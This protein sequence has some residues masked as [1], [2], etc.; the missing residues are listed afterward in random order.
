MD[1]LRIID[2]VTFITERV[3]TDCT[4]VLSKDTVTIVKDN[5]KIKHYYHN[6]SVYL[7][8]E[9]DSDTIVKYKPFEIPVKKITYNE[10]ETPRWFWIILL[11]FVAMIIVK[12]AMK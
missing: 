4:F 9:C 11:I 5:L 1:T 6:D 8:G 12:I 10:P 2:T 7:Y 3:Q